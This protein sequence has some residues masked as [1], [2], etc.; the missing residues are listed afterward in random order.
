MKV[1]VFSAAVAFAAVL[2]ASSAASARQWPRALSGG[3]GDSHTS[4]VLVAAFGNSNVAIS[5]NSNLNIADVIQFGGAVSS[6]IVQSGSTDI[7]HVFQIG[8]TTASTIVQVGD[9]NEASV[10]QIGYATNSLIGQIGRMNSGFVL[11]FG[12]N[13]FSG[14]WQF[15]R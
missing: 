15:G 3:F 14:I 10:K 4:F 9:T 13:N 2:T 7:A 11:Q 8:R 1:K 6:T 12:R 5:Q